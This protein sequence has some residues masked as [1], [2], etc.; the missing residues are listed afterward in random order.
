M[1]RAG[2]VGKLILKG[3]IFLVILGLIMVPLSYMKRP[4]LSSSRDNI[5]G[6]YDQRKNSLDVVFVGTSGTMSAFEPMRAYE[7]AGFTSYNFATNEMA[8][9]TLSFAVKEVMK[10]QNPRLMV[11]DVRSFIRHDSLKEMAA[12]GQDASIRYNTDPYKYSWN[13]FQLIWDN[14]PHNKGITSY[15]FDFIKYHD[16]DLTWN[17]WDCAYPSLNKG[18]SFMGWGN[19]INYP[20]PTDE[21][22]PLDGEMDSALDNL[23]AECKKLPCQV[24]FLYYPYPIASDAV[25]PLENVNY[26]EQKVTDAGFTFWNLDKNYD[27]FGFDENVDYWNNGHWNIYGSEKVTAYMIPKLKEAY[28]LPDHRQDPAYQSWSD[29]IDAFNGSVLSNMAQIDMAVDAAGAR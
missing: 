11:V 17:N 7:Q 24:L 13:R 25:H 20:T 3:L 14:L 8:V 5:S 22:V 2:K 16:Q 4:V 1:Q 19:E 21:V 15:F 23:I 26:I 18:Y 6:F 27:D 10:T 12:E 9:E 28:D 29:D